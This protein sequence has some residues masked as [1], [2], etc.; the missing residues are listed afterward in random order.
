MS[1]LPD[2]PNCDTDLLVDRGNRE[3]WFRCHG[4]GRSFGPRQRRIPYH[5][6][7]EWTVAASHSTRRVVHA[8]PDCHKLKQASGTVSWNRQRAEASPLSRC[9]YCGYQED[10]P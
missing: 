6:R 9:D 7:D 1:D 10:R 8:D 3:G 5:A 4:C 2:C